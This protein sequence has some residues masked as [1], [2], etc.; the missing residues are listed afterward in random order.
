MGTLATLSHP[1]LKAIKK[2]EYDQAILEF[3]MAYDSLELGD[4][5]E[6]ELNQIISNIKKASELDL[7]YADACCDVISDYEDN[8]EC[9]FAELRT[10]LAELLTFLDEKDYSSTYLSSYL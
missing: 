1:S 5:S 7:E 8:G 3:A 10:G 2:S 9:V 4:G 6:A